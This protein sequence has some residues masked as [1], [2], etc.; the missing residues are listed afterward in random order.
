MHMHEKGK[1]GRTNLSTKIAGRQRA[2][3]EA[4]EPRTLL[5]GSY[6]QNTF[7]SFDDAI[8]GSN[9]SGRL[10][11]DADRN[12]YGT[13][14]YGGQYS[15]GSV[16]KVAA[17]SDS[18]TTLASF[19]GAN[20][21]EPVGGLVIDSDG[22]LYGTATTGGNSGAG[23]VFEVA[24]GSNSITVLAEFQ[25][26]NGYEPRGGLVIDAD[27]NLYGTTY[28]GGDDNSGTVFEVP[29][30]GNGI[31]VIASLYRLSTGAN[32]TA[33]L[34][35]DSEGH[36]YGTTVSG[37][38]HGSGTVFEVIP[39]NN[40]VTTLT[41]FSS[42]SDTS[43]VVYSG[44]TLYGTTSHGGAD[45]Y[46][47][48]FEMVPGIGMM[49]TLVSFDS[50]TGGNPRAGLF[51]DDNGD[52]YGTASQDGPEGYGIVFKVAAGSGTLT[53]LVSLDGSNGGFPQTELVMDSA[54]TLYG[55]TT[56]GGALG[57]GTVFQLYHSGA[58][59]AFITSQPTN[60]SAGSAQVIS[61]GLAHADGVIDV[62][63]ASTVTLE[64]ASAPSGASVGGT[65]S[66]SAVNGIAEFS[67][68]TFTKP[69]TYT[70]TA[71]S[72]GLTS[73]TT[74]TITVIPGAATHLAIAQQPGT[75]TTAGQS[76]GTV[77]VDVQDAYG[78]RVTTDTSTVTLSSG[79]SISGTTS[80]S[81]VGGVATFSGLSMTQA[82]SHTL[83]AT[84]GSL[85][86]ASTNPFTIVAAVAAKLVVA[87]QPPATVIAGRAI[88]TITLEVQDSYGNLVTTD[89]STVTL[90]TVGDAPLGGTTSVAAVNGVAT[91]STL[92]IGTPG[93]HTLSASGGTLSS[94]T[95]DSITVTS[96]LATLVITAAATNVNQGASMQLSVTATDELGAPV[97][98]GIVTW[99]LEAGSTGSID[100][101]GVFT[102]GDSAGNAVI[103]AT[104][105][106]HTAVLT[107]AVNGAQ[108][109][110]TVPAYS[111]MLAVTSPTATLHVQAAQD[112][113]DSALIYTWEIVSQPAGVSSRGGV[114]AGAASPP[115]LALFSINGTHAA[116]DTAVTF[117]ASGAYTF[118]VTAS[119]GNMSTTSEV[120]VTAI[121]A[122]AGPTT[123]VSG[124][125]VV[126]DARSITEFVLTFNGALDPATAQDVRGYQ[127]QRGY[128]VARRPSGLGISSA[129]Y[130]S[131]AHTVTLKLDAPMRMRN[132]NRLVHLRG[133][134]PYAVR[135]TGG[136]A[137]NAGSS[138]A[139]SDDFT[140]RFRTQVSKARKYRT[141]AGDMVKLSLAGPGKIVSLFPANNDRP[142][143]YLRNTI[144]ERSVLTGKV[145]KG[146]N[147]A[148][149]VVITQLND[150]SRASVH[151]DTNFHVNAYGQ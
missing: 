3:I 4:M 72:S 10:V 151:L 99:S 113:S 136:E 120:Q 149:P 22:N 82:G 54:R 49:T 18:I 126:G 143:I 110:I 85:A 138:D 62:S 103:R 142:T 78:N 127:I 25:G 64:I 111:E 80:V 21:A 125:R 53:N 117:L 56:Y 6:A 15:A 84:R 76:F 139:P 11:M 29:A 108:P 68:L 67:G 93:V 83:T 137:V 115:P 100:Q 14:R 147:G 16:F 28:G 150:V 116:S 88:G 124:V 19:D 95:T 119:D 90:A 47:S 101:A 89:T 52:L 38:A 42:L 81:A 44:G 9:P 63:N 60:V 7:A 71:R 31:N 69:G 24:A 123:L 43:H 74:T 106:E 51:V 2:L 121:T 45:G 8:T 91:F 102:A 146:Q 61:V 30:G 35:M 94:A 130:D 41:S 50:T 1:R 104:S 132:G 20:G 33:G 5:S 114:Q 59:Q 57:N 86:A 131:Q 92:S 36:L 87:G 32:P 112:D 73:A 17:G 26:Y 128:K 70:L 141:E 46:G 39:G 13:T 58:A 34:T 148:G 96:S 107:I 109:T 37:G 129:V 75:T 77:Q 118:R 65:L 98:L 145:R 27:G 135:D 12:L 144:P 97:T 55:T 133:T 40:T 134:G 23:T 140:Y 105:G 79:S 66:V 122:A 48:V